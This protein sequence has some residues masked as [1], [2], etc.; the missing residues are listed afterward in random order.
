MIIILKRS[1][2]NYVKHMILMLEEIINLYQ[3]LNEDQFSRLENKIF[4]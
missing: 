1:N 4:I 3:F 2:K